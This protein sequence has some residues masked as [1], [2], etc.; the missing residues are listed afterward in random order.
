MPVLKAAAN[1]TGFGLIDGDRYGSNGQ[2]QFGST[3]TFYRQIRNLI[4]DMTT[5]PSSSSATGVHWPTAQ[6]TSLQNCVFRMSDAAGTQHQGIF[7]ESGK[8]LQLRPQR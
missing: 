2:L 5:I 6:A 1:F 4:F 7:I 3:N 8:C